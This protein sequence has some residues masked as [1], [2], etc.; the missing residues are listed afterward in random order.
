GTDNVTDARNILH[1]GH[2]V[3]SKVMNKRNSMVNNSTTHQKHRSG[4]N[5]GENSHQNRSKCQ[6]ATSYFLFKIGLLFSQ[7]QTDIIQFDN[8]RD[9]T[10]NTNGHHHRDQT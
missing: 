6:Q 2:T 3:S 8:Q 7:M 1:I 10:I 5:N 4:S 9:K